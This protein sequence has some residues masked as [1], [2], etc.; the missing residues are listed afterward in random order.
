MIHDPLCPAKDCCDGTACDYCGGC[1]CA[2]IA[3]VKQTLLD[4][5]TDTICH[6]QER[7]WDTDGL[8]EQEQELFDIIIRELGELRTQ[9]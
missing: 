4:K 9:G 6:T 8:S 1:R 3:L 2:L 5:V 7:L